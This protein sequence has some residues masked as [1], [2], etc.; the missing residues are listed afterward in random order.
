MS[1]EDIFTEI[2]IG[3]SQP[4]VILCDRG[5]MDGAAYCEKEIWQALLDETG[6]NSVQLRDRRYEAVFHLVTAA[7]G[8]ETYYEN[9][10]NSARY[11]TLEE[12]RSVDSKLMEAW[13]GYPH[14]M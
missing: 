2:A 13:V 11:E 5:V 9:N 8:A 10:T 3:C 12:A 1:L 7:I 4:V 14:F 6:W